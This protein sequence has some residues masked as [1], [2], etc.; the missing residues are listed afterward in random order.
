MPALLFV[1]YSTSSLLKRIPGILF[2]A[3]WRLDSDRE[4]SLFYVH[5]PPNVQILNVVLT[6]VV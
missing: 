4:L 6:A 2:F 3:R 5:Q 1:I